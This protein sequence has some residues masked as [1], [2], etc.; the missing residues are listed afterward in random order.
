MFK[1]QLATDFNRRLV[2]D[3]KKNFPRP[4]Q[5][6]RFQFFSS[7]EQVANRLQ[8]RC[9]HA[10]SC[11]IDGQESLT[12]QTKFRGNRSPGSGEE[13][14]LKD[15]TIHGCGGHLGHVTQMPR[16]YPRWLHIKFGFD[17]ASGFGG[18]V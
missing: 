16:T 7:R 5:P 3:L 8:S 11:K 12:L 9:K 18:D 14:I 15:F 2:G 6:L 4:L 13:D 17:W 1:R 10:F